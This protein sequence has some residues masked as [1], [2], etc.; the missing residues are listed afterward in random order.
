LNRIALVTEPEE[1]FD[2]MVTIMRATSAEGKKFASLF[3]I[4]VS[5]LKKV[6]QKY[7]LDVS[8]RPLPFY[9]DHF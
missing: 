3:V 5:L 4:V 2:L 8:T 6:R 1:F 9:F 7:F